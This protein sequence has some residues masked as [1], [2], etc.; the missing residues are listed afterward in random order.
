[1]RTAAIVVTGVAVLVEVGWLVVG[2]GEIGPVT[3]GVLALIAMATVTLGRVRALIVLTR[4]A[5]G[6]L[7]AGSVADRFGL[8]GPPRT[9]GVSWGSYAEF[10]DYT[11]TLLP[12]FA[13][14]A[15][16]LAAGAATVAEVGLGVAL[17]IGVRAR[18]S[19]AAAAALFTMFAV[20]M[21]TSV[22][23]AAMAGYAVPVMIGGALL[24]SACAAEP[25]SSERRWIG[26]RRRETA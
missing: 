23:F 25:G 5:L 8:F 13:A 15:A 4:V 24:V 22:G 26:S 1:M 12:G 9:D 3:I 7:L 18:M 11:R 10:V 19:A 20:A 16:P 2:D 14:D 17:I 21:V 6:V